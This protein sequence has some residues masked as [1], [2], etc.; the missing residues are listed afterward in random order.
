MKIAIIG[1]GASGVMA[2][3]T[4]SEKNA[5]VQIIEK[6]EKLCKKLFITGKGRCNIT[7]NCNQDQFLSNIVTNKRFLFSSIKSF[8][9][10]N[11]IN[12]FEKHNCSLKTER[13]GRVFPFSDKSSDIIKV[14][15]KLLKEKNVEINL[16]TNCQ[17]IIK[18]DKGFIILTNKGKFSADKVIVC[19]GG[20]SYSQTGS[21][22]QIY[23]IITK[24]GHTITE[25]KP[26]LCPILLQEDVSSLAGLSLKNVSIQATLNGKK[27]YSDFGEMLFTHNGVSGPIVLSM[28]S[29]INKSDLKNIILKVDLKPALDQK[30]LISR[31]NRD[32]LET[33]NKLFRNSLNGLLPKSIIPFIIKLSQIPA[34]IQVNSITAKQRQFL[35]NLLKNLSF[36]VKALEDIDKAIITSGGVN[37]KEINPSTMESKILKGLYFAGEVIDVDALTG[38]FN[39]QIAL[40]TAFTAANNAAENNA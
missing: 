25:I 32:F 7:N 28:S 6:N 11:T 18:N 31:I 3:V 13:G 5:K 17:E 36:K 37:V 14:F 21:N 19:G 1:G 10:E 20:K 27:I 12:F 33:Q 35:A 23:S 38:G 2:A 4:A 24:L 9:P 39:L 30:M 15:E 40:C 26:A 34:D 8:S 16:N 29:F 22:G